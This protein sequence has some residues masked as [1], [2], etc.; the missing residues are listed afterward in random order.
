MVSALCTLGATLAAWC[1]FRRIYPRDVA[2]L[3]GL[4][5]AVNWAWA[6]AGTGIQSEPLYELLGQLAILAA[7]RAARVGDLVR[8]LLLASLLAACLLTRQVAVGLLAAVL[9]DL[10]LRREWSTALKVTVLT[11]V[12]VSP[13]LAWLTL[14]GDP[15]RTQASLLL[16]GSSGLMARAVSQAVF[17]LQRIPDQ[18]D[19]TGGRAGHGDPARGGPGGTGERLGPGFLDPGDRGPEPDAVAAASATGGPD[20][21]ARRS[22]CSW[23]GPTR[24]RG[25]S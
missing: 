7:M 9:L 4:A 13:W 20:P 25:V 1:W 6:R 15:Q 3:L 17:Y 21:P 16:K 24:R 11:L 18:L 14:V 23:R 12:L 5:L 10:C 22:S 2:V 19:R 8:T